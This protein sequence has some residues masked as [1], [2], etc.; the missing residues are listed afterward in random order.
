MHGVAAGLTAVRYRS[1]MRE[2]IAKAAT[3]PAPAYTT[4]GHLRLV[5]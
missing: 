1:E 2:A 4:A 3:E 5:K